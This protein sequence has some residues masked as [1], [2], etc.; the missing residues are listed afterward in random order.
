MH[1]G[2]G[3]VPG[4]VGARHA[5]V[6]RRGGQIVDAAR[7]GDVQGVGTIPRPGGAAVVGRQPDRA[8]ALDEGVE[9]FGDGEFRSEIGEDV[10]TVLESRHLRCTAFEYK[11]SS[12]WSGSY[13]FFNSE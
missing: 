5:Q 12:R 3:H 11:S 7:G 10:G 9:D 13:R 6:T 2:D 8:V 1:P 4:D